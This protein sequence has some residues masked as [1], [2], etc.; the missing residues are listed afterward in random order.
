M[1]GKVAIIANPMS[2]RDVRR[3]AARAT[4]VTH[5]AK[6]AQVHWWNYQVGFASLSASTTPMEQSIHI[7]R[8]LQ[9]GIAWYGLLPMF[10]ELNWWLES[11]GGMKR[12][13]KIGSVYLRSPRTAP[14]TLMIDQL[15]GLLESWYPRLGLV[16]TGSPGSLLL[17]SKQL[18]FCGYPGA[19]RY[20]V[21]APSV[22]SEW[23][24]KSVGGQLTSSQC[25]GVVF[26]F[27]TFKTWCTGSRAHIQ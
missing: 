10:R 11:M 16:A 1:P 12:E 27:N 18:A 17:Q 14:M 5:E 7:A 20:S 22:S 21:A 6:A 15:I 19:W 23:A 9:C 25:F 26:S 3:L 24:M 2:G 8:R 4:A 13:F